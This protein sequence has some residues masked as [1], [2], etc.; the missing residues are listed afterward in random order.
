MTERRFER[1]R[2]AEI[3]AEMAQRPLIFFPLGPLEWHGPHLPLGTDPLVAYAVA[4]RVAGE[5]GGLVLPP[6][7]CGA[8]RERSPQQLKYMGFGGDEW[9]IGMDFPAN[10]LKSLYFREEYLALLVREVLELLVRQGYRLIV[11]VNGHGAAN[12]LN[13]LERLAAEFTAES[14]ARV[15]HVTAWK[16][17]DEEAGD[18]GH[19]SGSET[20]HMMALYPELVDLSQLPPLPEPL[21]NIDW[22]VVD[23]ATF[24]GDPA[25]DFTNRDDPRT[26]ASA[27]R[28]EREIGPAVAYISAKVTAALQ[29]LGY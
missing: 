26:S 4:Q 29:D 21:R 18:S 25:P 24:D 8:E 20:S 16:S 15:L 2:P 23:A 7:Y 3:V 19:A 6:F 27:E 14:P 10:V 13:L 17:S 11:I 1:L 12:H 9:I 28:G 5:V 22:A